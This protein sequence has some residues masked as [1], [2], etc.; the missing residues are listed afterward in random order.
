MGDLFFVEVSF[1]F[2]HLLFVI[3]LE[4]FHV[5]MSSFDLLLG[6]HEFTR[7]CKHL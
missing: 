7:G 3:E 6:L 5:F 1:Q 2:L 4:N